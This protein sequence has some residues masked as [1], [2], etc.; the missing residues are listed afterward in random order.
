MCGSCRWLLG[1]AKNGGQGVEADAL[2]DALGDALA[3]ALAV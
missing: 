1:D 3:D 2:A